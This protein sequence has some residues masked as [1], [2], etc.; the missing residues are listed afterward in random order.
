MA[1][2]GNETTRNATSHGLWALIEHPDQFDLLKS[3]TEGMIDTAVDE[4]VRFASHVL[5]FRRTAT[6]DTEINGQKINAGDKVVMW[7][8]SANRD[9]SEFE[10]PFSLDVQRSPNNHVGF[11]GGGPH[12]CLGANLA[13][14]ELKII[15]EELCRSM[16]DVSLAGQPSRLRSNFINGVKHM[17]I[18]FTPGDKVH[19][20]P[21][22]DN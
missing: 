9:D 17:P 4:I 8:V 19:P 10:N 15:F 7:H 11:G 16:P 13:K 1:V 20:E 18:S 2:A 12:F 21:N 3:D 6:Q 22:F 14:L 5:H